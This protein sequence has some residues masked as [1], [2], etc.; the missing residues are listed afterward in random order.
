MPGLRNQAGVL[1]FT[2]EG[3]DVEDIGSALAE[4]GIA[5]RTG[6]HCAP[7]A[8]Q[9]AGTLE[10]G[11]VRVSFSD[12]NRPDEVHRFLTALEDCLH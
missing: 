11:T 8:H 6:I 4:R 7:L 1:S 9:S 10:S 3:R 2:A 5:V 12:F